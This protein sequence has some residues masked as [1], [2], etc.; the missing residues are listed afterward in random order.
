[1]N[2]VND[3][4]NIIGNIDFSATLHYLNTSPE[5]QRILLIAKLAFM[6]ISFVLVGMIIF[7]LSRTHYLEWLFIQ[8]AAQFFT[9]R[10]LG[11]YKITKQWNK[12]VGRLEAGSEPDYKLAVIEADDMLESSLKKMGYDGQTLEEKLGKLSSAT[13]KNIDQLYEVHRL[14]NNIVHDPD[15]RLTLDEAKKSM[16][17]YAQAFRNLQI[18]AD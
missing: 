1:M 2:Q 9:M 14:R 15:Y 11:A 10:P 16:D 4:L 17:V 18:L 3:F 8:D 5:I 7:F 13:L 12:I 6:A